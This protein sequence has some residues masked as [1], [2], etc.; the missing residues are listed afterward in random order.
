MAV[1]AREGLGGGTVPAMEEKGSEGEGCSYGLCCWWSCAAGVGGRL[2]LSGMVPRGA[3]A[4]T[5]LMAGGRECLRSLEGG[6]LVNEA[7]GLCAEA[8]DLMVEEEDGEESGGGVGGWREG[9]KWEEYCWACWAWRWEF[10]RRSWYSWID[11][12]LGLWY[13]TVILLCR[14]PPCSFATVDVGRP[15]E[16]M[17]PAYVLLLRTAQ[18]ENG[19]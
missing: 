11:C 2:A 10:A 3:A 8:E 9:V 13:S 1:L 12:R 14:R 19:Y 4:L 18:C 7:R 17:S 16:L 5:A 15:F 6:G